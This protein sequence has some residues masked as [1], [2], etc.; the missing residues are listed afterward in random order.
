MS[1]K[2]G[3]KKKCLKCNTGLKKS[4]TYELCKKCIK[5]GYIVNHCLKCEK[6]IA[7]KPNGNRNCDNCN[8]VNL[9]FSP[10]ISLFAPDGNSSSIRQYEE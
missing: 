5:K 8:K 3:G 6:K 10:I 2:K 7:R 4:T 9:Q 1:I